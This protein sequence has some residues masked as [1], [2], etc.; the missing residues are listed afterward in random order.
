VIVEEDEI[1]WTIGEV[2]TAELNLSR[3]CA[4]AR[5]FNDPPI[6]FQVCRVIIDD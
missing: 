6:D 5:C 4:I 2:Y 3:Q 1:G